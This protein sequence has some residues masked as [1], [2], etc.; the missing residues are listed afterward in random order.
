MK[1]ELQIS[2]TPVT[3]LLLLVTVPSEHPL[4]PVFSFKF[5]RKTVLCVER[6][7]VQAMYP[8]PLTLSFEEMC[9]C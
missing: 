2:I 7:Y 9:F 3:L 6:T 5:K 8:L 1:K 4:Q